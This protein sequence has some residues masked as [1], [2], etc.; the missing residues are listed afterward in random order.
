[1]LMFIVVV[2]VLC[3]CVIIVPELLETL[4]NSQD[5]RSYVTDVVILTRN[6]YSILQTSII[7]IVVVVIVIIIII[8]TIIIITIITIIIIVVWGITP[9]QG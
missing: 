4:Q 9:R 3:L 5:W 2:Q 1:M 7:I 8:I 6:R